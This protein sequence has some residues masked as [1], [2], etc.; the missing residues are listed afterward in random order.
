M[1]LNADAIKQILLHREPFLF[2]DRVLELEEG[3]RAVA[4]KDIT[5]EEDFFKGHFPGMPIMPGVLITEAMAQTAVIL[6]DTV[7]HKKKGKKYIYYLGKVN[8]RFKKPVLP[9]SRLKLVAAPLKI[10]SESGMVRT[11]AYVGDEE[12]AKGEISFAR[13]EL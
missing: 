13:R 4:V 12:V 6:A 10:M 9:P 1:Q 7:I 3:K 8:I 2:I 5:G 11:E